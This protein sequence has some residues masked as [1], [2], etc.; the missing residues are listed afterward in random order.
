MTLHT[1][2]RFPCVRRIAAVFTLVG[3]LS[4]ATGCAAPSTRTD[5]LPPKTSSPHPAAD[6][7]AFA[8][9]EQLTAETEVQWGDGFVADSG[10]KREP[11]D[12]PG[13]WSYTNARSTCTA[14]FRDGVLGDAAGM[15]DRE[16]TDA[17]MEQRAGENWLGQEFVSDG[18]FLPYQRSER[19]VA[20][21]QF[22][23]TVNGFGYFIAARAFVQADAAVW[24]IVTCEGEPIGPVAEEVLSKNLLNVS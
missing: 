6:V 15:D 22:N 13:R 20:N 21:R 4:T 17:V 3:F 7:F 19:R 8:D 24:V 1:S 10:W 16:A 9:G 12:H 2:P 18:T 23:F 5:E 11:S 14:T